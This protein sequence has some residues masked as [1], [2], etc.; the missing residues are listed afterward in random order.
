MGEFYREAAIGRIPL[1][2]ERSLHLQVEAASC[3]A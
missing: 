3:L 2:D 1:S